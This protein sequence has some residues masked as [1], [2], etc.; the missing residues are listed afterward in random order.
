MV[1]VKQVNAGEPGYFR[2]VLVMHRLLREVD[3]AEVAPRVSFSQLTMMAILNESGP[4]R[5][6]DLA[7][8]M[9]MSQA[10]VTTSA[11]ILEKFGLLHRRKDLTDGRGVICVLTDFGEDKLETIT[12][13]VDE[14]MR[15]SL[16]KS[17]PRARGK[18]PASV[19]ESVFSSSTG[20]HRQATNNVS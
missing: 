19:M 12:R 20:A 2:I 6:Q 10:T 3:L 7:T 8:E 16:K 11:K 1:L 5:M 13:A 17:N 9:G 18:R 15:E 4:L 14:Q